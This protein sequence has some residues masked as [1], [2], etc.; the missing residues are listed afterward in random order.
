[1][2]NTLVEDISSTPLLSRATSIYDR[3]KRVCGGFFFFFFFFFFFLCV[4]VFWDN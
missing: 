2:M 3:T 4:C 1:M